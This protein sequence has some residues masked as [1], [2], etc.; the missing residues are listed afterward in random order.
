[1]TLKSALDD[2]T[3]TTLQAIRGLWRRLE[4]LAGLRAPGGDYLH[5]GLAKVH[6]DLAAQRA[7]NEAHRS[8]VS[9]VLR[10]PIGDLVKDAEESS[11]LQGLTPE[12]Y[13]EKL[14]QSKTQL[15]P[16]NPSGGA[17]RHLS[18]VLAALLS[19]AK[20]RRDAT[21]PAS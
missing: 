10:T 15:L 20:T 8:A 17:A 11:G 14:D 5:W 16:A 2:L 3:F 13:L 21:P 1:M 4:Y 12:A 9:K 7:L 19:L 6:G 18:S